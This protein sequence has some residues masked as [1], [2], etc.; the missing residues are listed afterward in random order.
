[1]ILEENTK[2]FLLIIWGQ[3]SD[4][5]KHKILAQDNFKKINNADSLGIL[6]ALWNALWNEAFSF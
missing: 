3:A 1:M 6:A 4:I 5:L 2:T